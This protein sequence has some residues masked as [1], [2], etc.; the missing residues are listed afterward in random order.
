MKT[1]V[2]LWDDREWYSELSRRAILESN[3]WAPEVLEPQYVDFFERFRKSHRRR[4]G[5]PLGH[6][7]DSMSPGTRT[8]QPRADSSEM[9]SR[10]EF[11]AFLNRRGL[12]GTGVEI[13][14]QNGA[15]ARWS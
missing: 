14:V 9:R 13:G 10:A 1:I 3:R 5:D 12:L 8:R 4:S 7:T 2:A 6:G 11:G 15:F